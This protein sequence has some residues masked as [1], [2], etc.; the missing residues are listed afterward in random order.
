[1][2]FSKQLDKRAKIDHFSV[3]VNSSQP[4]EEDLELQYSAGQVEQEPSVN[5]IEFDRG[6]VYA[7]LSKLTDLRKPKAERYSLRLS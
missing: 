4:T 7:R 3:E 2:V 1:M 6:S 5:E